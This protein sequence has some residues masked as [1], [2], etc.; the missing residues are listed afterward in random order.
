MVI[1]IPLFII[2]SIIYCFKTP[3]KR[4]WLWILFM[5]FGI[6]SFKLNWTTGD[7]EL[8]LLNIRL[9]GAGFSRSGTVAPWILSF[10]VPV[11]A[12]LFWIKKR[13]INK[14]FITESNVETE[15]NENNAP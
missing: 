15:V 11:G 9:L 2:L 12:I 3:L 8:Q 1:I 13:K 6:I 10:A 7:F 5:L 14:N 4:K